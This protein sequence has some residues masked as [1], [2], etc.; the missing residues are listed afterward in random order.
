MHDYLMS[1]LPGASGP[2]YMLEAVLTHVLDEL[3]VSDSAA[4]LGIL[5]CVNSNLT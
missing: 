1:S 3:A 4:M 2:T 5:R